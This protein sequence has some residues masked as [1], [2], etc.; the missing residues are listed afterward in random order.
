MVIM[1][2]PPGPGTIKGRVTGPDTTKPLV[3]QKVVLT[4]SVSATDTTASMRTPC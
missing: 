4:R 2:L 1:D 3:G